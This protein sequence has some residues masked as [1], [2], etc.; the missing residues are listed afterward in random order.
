[1]ASRRPR[2]T[3]RDLRAIETKAN[4]AHAALGLFAQN[5]FAGTSSRTIAQAAGVSNAL[6]FYHYPTKGDL[7]RGIIEHHATFGAEVA[8]VVTRLGDQPLAVVFGIVVTRFVAL[9]ASGGTEA[10]FFRLMLI[11]SQTSDDH[12]AVME[13]LIGRAS[14]S[15][16]NY[17]RSRIAAGEVRPD[18][19]PDTAVRMLFGALALH[20]MTSPRTTAVDHRAR[21]TAFAEEVVDIMTR[22]LVQPSAARAG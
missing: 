16:G 11:E 19:G 12:F 4:I 18:A 1:M 21:S 8:E 17:L 6:L 9:L 10:Q 2:P 3:S 14:E 15:L 7:L 22:G 13:S 20:V 5:G